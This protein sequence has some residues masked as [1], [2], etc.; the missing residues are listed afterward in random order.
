MSW[1]RKKNL[2]SNPDHSQSEVC[3]ISWMTL[4]DARQVEKHGSL[5]DDGKGG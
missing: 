5:L 4:G 1:G 3:N 2:R